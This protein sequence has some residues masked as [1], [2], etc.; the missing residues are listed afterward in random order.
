MNAT[1]DYNRGDVD[2]TAMDALNVLRLAVGLN[3]GWGAPA[4]AHDFIAADVNG[5]GAVT[6]MDA[7]ELL[8]H[9]VGLETEAAPRWVFV[10]DAADLSAVGRDNVAYQT[11]VALDDIEADIDV[12]MTGILLG[13]M[14]EFA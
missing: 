12:S 8:R 4:T 6:A 9:V 5:D 3:P 13:N 7:L 2:I 10:D 11:G 1:R 14:Q